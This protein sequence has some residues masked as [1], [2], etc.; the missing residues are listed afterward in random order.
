MNKKLLSVFSLAFLGTPY[1][2]LAQ[3][4][5]SNINIAIGSIN[6]LLNNIIPL[7]IGIAVVVFL[8]GIVRY[9][10]A[11]DDAEKRK[12]G[13]ALMAYGILAIF[14]MVSVWGLVGFLTNTF[15]LETTTPTDVPQVPGNTN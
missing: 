5:F 13:A 10:A 3:A 9:V 4:D 2:A 14:V 6:D 7:L 12:S 15:N 11:G 1:L 8:F